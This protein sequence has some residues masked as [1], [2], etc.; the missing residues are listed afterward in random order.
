MSTGAVS[1]LGIGSGVL[2]SSVIDQLKAADTA[3]I[4]TPITNKITTNTNKQQSMSLL[5]SLATSFTGSVSSLEGSS[6][7]QKRTVS[8]ANSAVS[9][10]ADTGVAIQNFS[11]SN[12]K[13]AT[14]NVSQSGSFTA[15]TNTIASGSG[16]FN[17]NVNGTDYKIAYDGSTTYDDLKTKIND[18]AGTDVSASILQ[19][20]DTSYSLILNSK[21]TGKAQQISLTDLSGKVNDTLKSDSLKS[22]AFSASS[23]KIATGSGTLTLNAGVTPSTFQYSATTSLSD[24]A[25]MINND[26]TASANVSASVIKNDLGTYN[27]VLTAKGPAEN[28][29]IS[30]TDQSSS[31]TLDSKLLFNTSADPLAPNGSATASSGGMSNIQAASDASFQYN[32][33]TVTRSTN[34]ISDI[35]AG[36]TINLLSTD[37]ASTAN[38]GIT[39]DAQP[40]KDAMQSLVDSYNAMSKQLTAMTQT[41]ATTGTV[42]LFN[43]DSSINRLDRDIKNILTS[44]SSS[45]LSLVQYGISINRD[46]TLSF[47]SSAFDTKMAES[48]D[49]MAA[50]FSGKTTIDSNGNSSTTDGVFNTLYTNLNNLTKSSGVLANLTTGLT[51][52]AT[53]LTSDKT[54][55]TDALT[56]RYDTMT[57]QF[58]AYDAIISNLNNE[59]SSLSTQISAYTNGS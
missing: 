38:I 48:P 41:D 23:S 16:Q 3:N 26:P 27:L 15:S 25:T 37:S 33:I 42:G 12:T 24:L 9:V 18:I 49:N 36:V 20:G 5:S 22:D 19:T 39:Q 40:I 30:L 47:D 13:L 14:T 2:T 29:P 53:S 31:G 57:Q 34:T 4:I 21:N 54:K 11:I 50:Y 46:G 35:T 56:A 8:G 28:Q 17:L 43:G 10:T 1:S 51:T 32:G 45:G 44:S 7:Y 6:L 55:A 58:I 52:E 59:F